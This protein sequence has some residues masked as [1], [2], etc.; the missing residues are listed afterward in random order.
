MK[1]GDR[2]FTVM[3][4]R[5]Q[6]ASSIKSGHIEFMQNRRIPALDDKGMGEYLN[7]VDQFGNGIRVP[8]TYYV[9]IIDESRTADQQRKVQLG[10][11]DHP[12]QLIYS[13][14]T[15][16]KESSKY[17]EQPNFYT[18]KD[19]QNEVNMVAIPLDVNELLI[20]LENTMDVTN[21]RADHKKVIDFKKLLEEMLK[22][23]NAGNED[24]NT[25]M[26][27]DEMSI[28]GNMK[29]SN[30]LARRIKWR[31]VDDD[32]SESEPLEDMNLND[33]SKV[34]LKPQ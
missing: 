14:D 22:Y 12:L 32:D 34:H 1:D 21:P 6:S 18:S 3:N 25:S 8:A 33:F 30:M 23:A 24:Y 29:L 2:V 16:Q 26:M 31:T 20:R 17:F 4:D 27:I 19:I 13:F 10:K 5:S 15:D 28:T 11:T 9:Q 7:E